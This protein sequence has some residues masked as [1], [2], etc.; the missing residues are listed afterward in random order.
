MLTCR[1]NSIITNDHYHRIGNSIAGSGAFQRPPHVLSDRSLLGSLACT[2][3]LSCAARARPQLLSF[4][5]YGAFSQY[6][7]DVFRRLFFLLQPW[8]LQ[9]PIL[10]PAFVP[11]RVLPISG[12]PS[13]SPGTQ[14]RGSYE[15]LLETTWDF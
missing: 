13:L 14:L 7:F 11:L 1:G 5:C 9:S 2:R 8:A 12:S 4:E 10:T 6:F 15:T 3:G